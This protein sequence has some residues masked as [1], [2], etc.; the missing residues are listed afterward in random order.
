MENYA[1][2]TAYYDLC[3]I[4]YLIGLKDNKKFIQ[5]PIHSLGRD[6]CL[7]IYQINKELFNNQVSLDKNIKTIRH[8]IKQYNKKGENEKIY[9]DIV[10]NS[11]VQFGH[12]IDNIGLFIED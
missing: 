8:K 1:Y 6:A 9:N 7:I 10:Y 5:V 4:Y 3:G 12:D 11:I 2:K